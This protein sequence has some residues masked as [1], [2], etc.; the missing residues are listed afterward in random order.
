V[1]P[2]QATRDQLVEAVLVLDRA[3]RGLGGPPQAGDSERVAS[4]AARTA[5]L[6]AWRAGDRH[7][8]LTRVANAIAH[9]PADPAPRAAFAALV[10]G[11][12][13]PP[14]LQLETRGLAVLAFADE[15][16]ERPE[17]LQAYAERFGPDADAT[18]VLYAPGWDAARAG[19]D[20]PG[21]LAAGGIDAEAGPDLLALAVPRDPA[22]EAALADA[23]HA[24]LTAA[25]P[26]AFAG[27]PN[28]EGSDPFE[29]DV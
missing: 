2:E 9:D 28:L 23:V 8:A 25:P 11:E 16:A 26:D 29:V 6:A 4:R 7:V 13:P 22:Y 19:A 12:A 5:G 15:V 1:R 21:V 3:Y 24:L 27:V 18:L 14:G 20:L 10:R 17:L